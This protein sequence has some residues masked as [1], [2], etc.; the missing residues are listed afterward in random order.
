MKHHEALKGDWIDVNVIGG[1]PSRRGQI[2]EVLGAPGHRHYRVRW[3]ERHE[4]LHFP[5]E[6]TR[7]LQEQPD[8]SLVDAKE[9]A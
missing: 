7:F 2:V 1:G 3:D 5:A 9:P 4:S 8:G 6:G